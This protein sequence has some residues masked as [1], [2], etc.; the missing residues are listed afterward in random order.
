MTDGAHQTKQC[1]GLTPFPSRRGATKCKYRLEK[2]SHH[3]K[4]KMKHAFI[5]FS[6]QVGER[7]KFKNFTAALYT[8]NFSTIQAFHKPL[9]THMEKQGP[10]EGRKF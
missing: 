6:T 3:I 7:N 9:F 8:V 2:A 1:H 10:T 4:K 5:L